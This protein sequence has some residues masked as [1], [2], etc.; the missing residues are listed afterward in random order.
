MNPIQFEKNGPANV[1]NYAQ[2]IPINSRSKYSRIQLKPLLNHFSKHF[3]I[4]FL[5][6]CQFFKNFW[7]KKQLLAR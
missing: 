6:K 1:E 2:E 5:K 4:S 3:Q 7:L